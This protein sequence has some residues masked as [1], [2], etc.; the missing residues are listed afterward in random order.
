[1]SLISDVLAD[2]NME[3]EQ[4][5]TGSFTVICSEQGLYSYLKAGTDHISLHSCRELH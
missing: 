4:L 1:M 5:I 3:E 2:P